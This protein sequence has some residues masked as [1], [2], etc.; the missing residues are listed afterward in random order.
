M[1]NGA[2]EWGD[3]LVVSFRCDDW[4]PLYE[5]WAN[6][7]VP[8][9]PE[10]GGGDDNNALG[11]DKLYITHSEWATE[12]G[13]A[14]RSKRPSGEFKALPV[15]CC[16]LTL[17]PFTIPVCTPEG[18]VF[19]LP[20]ILPHLERD[21]RNPVTGAPLAPSSLLRLH[22]SRSPT[23]Q[24]HCPI[25]LK[26]FTDVSH[27]VA[28]RK[29]GQVYS[30]E[31]LERL[32]RAD[33]QYCDFFTEETVGRADLITL[34]DPTRLEGRNMA[35]FLHVREAQAA[36]EASSTERTKE[37]ANIRREGTTET[38]LS[39]LESQRQLDDSKPPLPLRSE[40]GNSSSLASTAVTSARMPTA[41]SVE[42]SSSL[43][44][45]VRHKGKATI[46]TNLGDLHV[47]LFCPKVPRTTYNF[48]QL[49]RRGYYAGVVFH[50]LIPGFVIQGGD[51]TGTG[52][53]GESCFPEG[54]PFANEF[55]SGLSHNT[56]GILSMANKA[57]RPKSNTSQ[58]FITLAP[59]VHL[60]RTHPVF[61]RVLGGWDVL[62]RMEQIGADE[63]GRPLRSIVIEDVIVV[64]DPFEA[65][66]ERQRVTE[67]SRAARTATDPTLAL[68][69]AK[70]A[71]NS[72]TTIGK[73]INRR[74]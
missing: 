8:G 39:S 21:A 61:G 68:R 36:A 12:Y 24:L 67:V 40:K 50:R 53:G 41:H 55:A 64:E 73:Y 46:R 6:G 17:A 20:H 7:R 43:F 42:E 9:R 4:S 71:V 57:G 10:E 5:K 49:A 15:D 19:D 29:T 18:V 2:N 44:S 63:Q 33:G 14:K 16:A 69:R 28:N 30:L 45:L 32:A 74:S 56:R 59:H 11:V 65:H 60:D 52:A 27:I 22:Y 35:A 26:T 3:G 47:E 54:R 58:F 34:Q 48:L 23:G 38:I 31:G 1:I 70:A 51:P 37:P 72:A 25:T 66:Q 13:G 62:D